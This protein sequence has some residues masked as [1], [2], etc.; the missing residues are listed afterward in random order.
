MTGV[1]RRTPL[2]QS[3]S[4]LA[5][6]ALLAGCGVS[7]D[8]PRP[9]LAAEV[10]GERLSVRDLDVLVDAVCTSAEADEAAATTTRGQAQDQLL[11]NWIAFQA[12]LDAAE[13]AGTAADGP[14][15]AVEEVP[16][17][18]D[19]STDEQDAVEAYLTLSSDARASAEQIAEEAAG[20][21]VEL[22]VNPRYGLD[23]GDVDLATLLSAGLPAAD[24][25][26][27]V[28]VSD[29]AQPA[30]GEQS[31]AELASLPTGQL[32]GPRPEAGAAGAAG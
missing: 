27:S 17:W 22:T 19:M 1:M 20:E 10:G 31:A 14:A 5:S 16:G 30:E 11:Q 4:V 8:E 3:L 29:E 12:V 6:V 2:L 32:C 26:L 25:E 21:Q 23:T 24:Q 13:A 9:G 28:A 18:E 15:T 7:D